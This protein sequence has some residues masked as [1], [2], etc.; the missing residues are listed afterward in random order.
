MKSVREYQNLNF[1]RI[2]SQEKKPCQAIEMRTLKLKVS[3]SL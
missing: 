2:G 1:I 3:Y